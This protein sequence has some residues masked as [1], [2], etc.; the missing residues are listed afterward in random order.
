MILIMTVEPGFGGQAF[1]NEMLNKIKETKEYIRNCNKTI[2]I[3]V[4]GGLNDITV[5]DAV[6]NGAN[7]I[8]AGSYI[9]HSDNYDKQINKLKESII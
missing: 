3:E 9:F 7:I 1:I 2:D 8:V 4:D 5:K 6:N